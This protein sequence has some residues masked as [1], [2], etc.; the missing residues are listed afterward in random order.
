[1]EELLK[2][3]KQLNIKLILENDSIRVITSNGKLSKDIINKLKNNKNE[4]IEYIKKSEN[5][6]KRV[7][8]P[9]D[10]TYKHLSISEVD[11][12][13]SQFDIKDIYQLTPMQKGIMFHALLNP[14]S[15]MYFQQTSIVLNGIVEKN[16][17]EQAFNQ[18]IECYDVFRTLFINFELEE[19]LQLVLKERRLKISYEDISQKVQEEQAKFLEDFK[20][21][22][23]NNTFDL[24][25]DHLFRVTLFKLSE[26]KY[27]IVWSHHHIIMDGWDISIIYNDIINTYHA[28]K[29]NKKFILKENY[30]YVNYIKWLGNQDK[31]EGLKYW[32]LF[33]LNYEG[34]NL[35]SHFKI[36]QKKTD[37]YENS[38]LHINFSEEETKRIND[39]S[40]KHN[41]TLNTIFQT[42][43]GVLLQKYNNCN[44]VVFG[45]VV[46]GRPPDI[47][48]I[49]EMIGLFINTVPVKVNTTKLNTIVDLISSLQ[50]S[51][52]KS[53]NYEYLSLA[54]IQLF[55][56]DKMN[57][58]DHIM[59]FDNYPIN[60][61]IGRVSDDSGIGFKIAEL[62]LY[63]Q[64]SYD[65]N[66]LISARNI[67]TVNIKFN[68]KLFKAETIN[69][70]LN[71]YKL[72]INKTL[73][74]PH[75]KISE[76]EII[77]DEEKQYL[78]YKLNKTETEYSKN[79]TLNQLF[80]EQK[81]KNPQ[82]I[83]LKYRDCSLTYN[84]LFK[85]YNFL[86]NFLI[87]KGIQVGELIPFIMNRS[88]EMIST[89]MSIVKAGGIY[90]P[91]E[92]YLPNSRIVRI[93]NSLS[94]KVLIIDNT[95][96]ERIDGLM[97]LGLKIELI[98]LV[99]TT[100]KQ[101]EF[102]LPKCKLVQSISLKSD[103]EFEPKFSR[104]IDSNEFAYIIHTSGSSG[105][106]KGVVVKHKPVINL[107]EWV[108]ITYG[109][110]F[111]DKV[112]FIS[113]IGFDLSVYDIFGI[114]GAGG[115]VCIV[116]NEQISNPQELLKIIFMEGI[117]Y[118][119]SAPA[120]L[121]QL[122]Y[123]LDDY[124]KRNLISAL[125]LVFLSGDWIPVTLP[126]AIRKVFK[127]A[128]IIGLGGATE[129]TIW[130]NFFTIKKVDS[131]WKSIPYGKP[132]QNAKYYILDD[133]LNPCC[134][135]IPGNLYIGGEC[136]ADG[137]SNEV[138]TTAE[139]FINNPFDIGIIYKT[140]DMARF[141]ED[142]N[143]EFLGRKDTQVKIR[144]QRIELGEIEYILNK[145]PKIS[146]GR[147]FIRENDSGDKFLCAYIICLD[148]ID[149]NDI[150]GF[151]SNDLP[152]Y[153]I[154]YHYVFIE[155]FP[156]TNNGKISLD[157]LPDPMKTFRN[158]IL[159]KTKVEKLL[160][161]I[162][163]DIL[164]IEIDRISIDAS[165]F[166]L[167]GHSLK[168]S[169]LV[170]KIHKE[171]GVNFPLRDVFLYLT[172]KEQAHQIELYKH[173]VFL[174]INK[175]EEK[176]YYSITSAQKRLYLLQQMNIISTVYNIPYI[177]SLD[178][179]IEKEKIEK[180]FRVLVNRH[181]SLRTSIEVIK[182]SIVQR[183]NKRIDFKIEEF[184]IDKSEEYIVKQGFIR[185]FSLSVAPLFRVGL[186]NIKDAGSLLIVDMHHIISDGI[187]HNIL[188]KEF[189][190]L[191]DEKKMPPLCLQYR[192]YAI[193]QNSIEEKDRVKKQGKYWLTKFEGELP[194]L[195]LF[196]DY[197]RPIVQSFDGAKVSFYLSNEEISKLRRVA[198]E[199]GLTAYMI[200]LSAFTLLLSKL[201]GQDDIIIGSPVAGRPHSD[202][203]RIVGVFVN[204]IAIR[205]KIE[206]RMDL[207]NFLL[208]IKTEAL[209]SFSNQDYKFE[210]IV[211]E[212]HLK[213]DL[214]RNPLFDVMFN[215]LNISKNS[216]D[217]SEL[218]IEE[219]NHVSSTSKFDLSLTVI[220][221]GEQLLF[222]F[223]YCTKLFKPESINRFIRYFKEVI[224]QIPEKL[225]NK[226]F[227]I[228]LTTKD[229]KEQLLYD[230]N[231]S[232]RNY[233]KRDSI[234]D[235][236]EEQ[237][238]K[239]PNSIAIIDKDMYLTY[240]GLLNL[241]N[242][243]ANKLLFY[244]VT[245]NSVVAILNERS[246]E[247]II[248][249]FG[250]LKAGGV[251]LPIS[252]DYPV[253][254]INYILKDSGTNIL[255]ANQKYTQNI[256]FEAKIFYPEDLILFESDTLVENKND[257]NTCDLAYII[258]TSGSTGKQ[259]GVP[260]KHSSVINL[261]LSMQDEYPL[262]QGDT[263]IFKTSYSFDVS[264]SEI[265]GWILN[266]AKLSILRSDAEKNPIE[267]LKLIR[268]HLVIQ[269]NFV[270]SAF[271]QFSNVIN[272]KNINM[273]I[274]LKYVFL[275]GEA[276]LHE[277]I[278][279]FVK[280]NPEV[281]IENL[282]G[283]TEAT[284]YASKYSINKINDKIPI[285][286]GLPNVK[287]FVLNQVNRLQAIGVPGELCISGIN[288]SIG[289]LNN[290]ELTH[291]KFSEDNFISDTKIYHTGDLA[292]WLH[293]GNIEYLGRIDHQVKV[294]G[295]RIELGE[296][297][298][299]ILKHKSVKE[300]I[301]LSKE[302]RSKE[303]Y[304]CAYIVPKHDNLE[305]T[306]SIIRSYLSD[307][308]PFYM[309]PSHIYIIDSIPVLSN[310]K[311]D[312][313]ALSNIEFKPTS[314][315]EPPLNQI[316][317]HLV[318]IWKE[319]LNI[320][321]V[322]LNDNFFEVG[323][324]SLK[325]IEIVN[326]LNEFYSENDLV[327][328]FFKYPTIKK[329]SSYLE[330]KSFS[331]PDEEV[332]DNGEMKLGKERLKNIKSKS[333]KN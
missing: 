111:N 91:L 159:P 95:Q 324:N 239:T 113:S 218:N 15:S 90:V 192:D 327:I 265:F 160:V 51:F 106:P 152:A 248:W 56:K 311:I 37:A 210:D 104:N 270:P 29:H 271:K 283:P 221:F 245:S 257:S 3:L 76:I 78:V 277:H 174:P 263:L 165:F 74:D 137:Y 173:E 94:C 21:K 300:T 331:K 307:L 241:S 57:L 299:N 150:K 268:K 252:I 183:I 230:F 80:D 274:S 52:L 189:I 180:A 153:M 65:L 203:E 60:E 328:K 132:I 42:F 84:E 185:S 116:P 294:R 87:N 213:R 32:K 308:L 286:K 53:R 280:L 313:I 45:A 296:I 267:I 216:V 182:G 232:S 225:D 19:P 220:D 258:Y 191:L 306:D 128:I 253:S 211:D 2:E 231:N 330:N 226:I 156:L 246:I 67:I 136:L 134:I 169:A 124:E 23:R 85:N 187:S 115:S 18:V 38:N 31:E 138:E 333:I 310:G 303:K 47:D 50:E 117:T 315:Y 266:G 35:L 33:L 41:V 17:L 244:G 177:I 62:D 69:K 164:Q 212:L 233:T 279:H 250:I 4:L 269:I 39:F 264:V 26:K 30:P 178:K 140:G 103:K 168:A 162:W 228:E 135:E 288:V 99:N 317:K 34:G 92:P 320:D 102:T 298:S 79:K 121:Q 316:E 63:E 184:N 6:K 251:Y 262:Q 255:L 59:V 243:L 172:V 319:V 5:N 112:L 224:K 219:Y 305:I 193:W 22:D 205:I 171:L 202:L 149:E 256:S 107:I 197:V 181:E 188:E 229:E 293:D 71:T 82:A 101:D 273:L 323:G 126:D 105:M 201:S 75:K 89:V 144:G 206:E 98:I 157:K 290:P 49:E 7:L 301:V 64:S 11:K 325:V 312:K 302:D 77:S 14:D 148:T 155:E 12:L 143:I 44:E 236:F 109:I 118:W 223:E 9:S 222:S 108:N 58:I 234:Y 291:E 163:S 147:V 208:Q 158:L 161:E 275:A 289:Y 194:K 70:I 200:L 332:I 318:S 48:G 204:T 129:A 54:D 20:K 254:K 83:A 72:L 209:E 127:D 199:N 166:E 285:G 217:L 292:R 24:M 122:V 215:L 46:S 321:Q 314:V 278:K 110:N 235:L 207:R 119:D 295:F 281:R 297:E 86:A 66:V 142:G 284:V 179:S 16:Y 125:R 247:V 10:F 36:N 304:L 93:L 139:K 198:N 27:C 114:L 68:N 322:G 28:I 242:N 141:L 276:I 195:N 237:V 240:S 96:I 55:A 145:N 176:E 167:G 8:T 73:L 123:Y 227:E 131:S 186:I 1:M 309:I 61:N 272:E 329:M 151:L 133:N 170:A 287:L 120:A 88:F 146:Q 25:R 214:S 81:Q 261:L 238:K 43:W 260:V 100:K 249:I 326:I 175:S 196:E 97:E 40:F 259:K 130:S 282:Y 154:P 13:S 190:D